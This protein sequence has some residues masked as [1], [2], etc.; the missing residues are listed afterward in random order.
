MPGCAKFN[1]FSSDKFGE[2]GCPSAYTQQGTS[3]LLNGLSNQTLLPAE[4]LNSV[5]ETKMN[6]I[7]GADSAG[8][9]RCEVINQL[10][11]QR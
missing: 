3:C 4:T 7:V 1:L 6:V 10:E 9:R 11:L 5:F 8:A 2:T